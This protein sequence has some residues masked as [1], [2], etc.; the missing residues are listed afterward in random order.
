MKL[1]LRF[2]DIFPKNLKNGDISG[3]YINLGNPFCEFQLFFVEIK[4]CGDSKKF[5]RIYRPK[6]QFG[7]LSRKMSRLVGFENGVTLVPRLSSLFTSKLC[8]VNPKQIMNCEKRKKNLV[9][10]RRKCP[11]RPD[12]GTLPGPIDWSELNAR[13]PS[14]KPPN[15]FW[16]SFGFRRWS[17]CLTPKAIFQE[18]DSE[19]FRVRIPRIQQWSLEFPE[20]IP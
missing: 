11:Q 8:W 5:C 20:W 4:F 13:I 18:M 12:F 15:H 6:A 16:I 9:E 3:R 14:W 1:Y 19:F 2:G 17:W 7:R 10:M